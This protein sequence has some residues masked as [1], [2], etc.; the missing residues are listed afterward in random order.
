MTNNDNVI[1]TAAQVR[2]MLFILTRLMGREL[3]E[4]LKQHG[5]RI[6]G[7]QYGALR[8]LYHH[9]IT[10]L[11]E[12]SR[13]MEL[14]PATLVPV[15]D[16]LERDRLLERRRDPKD[17]RRTLLSLTE[18]GLDILDKIPFI[19]RHNAFVDG[20]EKLGAERSEQ[21]VLLLHE[22]ADHMVASDERLAQCMPWHRAISDE[23]T[24]KEDDSE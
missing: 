10:T 22:L 17:R 14:T 12:L 7:L 18:N 3:D 4:Q 2:K 6:S 23:N 15:V 5:L 21:L 1:A 20:I 11:S 9:H 16:S 8:V 13:H 24:S 19:D